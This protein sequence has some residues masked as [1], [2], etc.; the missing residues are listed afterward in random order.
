MIK[1]EPTR[2]IEANVQ[3]MTDSE[4]QTR[5]AWRAA[6]L[7]FRGLNLGEAITLLNRVNRV[8]ISCAST[9]IEKL[10]VSGTFRADN[11]EAFVRIVETSFDLVADRRGIK[12][13][14]C[15][16]CKPSRTDHVLELEGL[17]RSLR[18]LIFRGSKYF[19]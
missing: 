13:S 17:P 6:L 7:E 2:P 5:M 4:M 15:G 10:R 9:T 16:A 3:Q 18:P 1:A 12:R 14:F 8:Q 19:A 11:P